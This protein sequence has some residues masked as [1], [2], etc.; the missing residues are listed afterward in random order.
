[1]LRRTRFATRPQRG[2][3]KTVLRSGA[4][5]FLGMSERR[6]VMYG[7]HHPEHLRGAAV[8]IN[9]KQKRPGQSLVI[10]LEKEKAK[11]HVPSQVL[12]I[13]GGPG[14]TRTSNQTVMSGRL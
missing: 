6:C 11:R 2:S 9:R 14:R 8:T 13:L 4:A 7:H 5:G 10:S 1:M 3:C 12:D